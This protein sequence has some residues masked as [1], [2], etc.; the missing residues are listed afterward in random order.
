MYSSILLPLDGSSFAEAA[1]PVALSLSHRTG[2][3]LRLVSVVAYFPTSDPYGW[4]D[5][6][7][8]Q[9]VDYLL[10]TAASIRE[11]AGGEVTTSAMAG[12]VA[13]VLQEETEHADIVVM[14]T[15]GRGGLSR[16]WLGSVADHCV[17][18]GKH[19]VLLVRPGDHGTPAPSR[20]WTVKRMLLPM[21]GSDVSEAIL[22]HAVEL[23]S[24]YGAAFHLTRIVPS[25]KQFN[26]PYPPHMIQANR[27]RI[28][29][30]EEEAMVYLRSHGDRLRSQGLTVEE[31]V[32]TGAQPAHG[33]LTEAE[34]SSCDFIA[35]SAHGRGPLARAVLGSTSDKV[36]RGTHLP[37]LLFRAPG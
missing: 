22:Q 11:K 13:T 6:L 1:L 9:A 7:R 18:H 5:T 27:D 3:A 15:H 19:P 32:V 21:D 16:A 34:A 35:I 23:G 28:E 8:E 14:A 17:R 24:L 12:H 26:S 2:A 36:V 25:S 33:I 31:K 10:E 30:E 20:E 4:Q 29:K 37:L